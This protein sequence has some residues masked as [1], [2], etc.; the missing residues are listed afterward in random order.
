MPPS[1]SPRS[2]RRRRGTDYHQGESMRLSRCLLLLAGL[3]WSAAYPFAVPVS[4]DG[5]VDH[6]IKM[7]RLTESWE[8]DVRKKLA[9]DVK[10]KGLADKHP[11]V[12]LHSRVNYSIKGEFGRSAFNFLLATGDD[13]KHGNE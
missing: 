3:L 7:K 12:V 13:Q 1:P 4:A 11:L 5:D 9:K 2:G 10:L 8:K 6:R